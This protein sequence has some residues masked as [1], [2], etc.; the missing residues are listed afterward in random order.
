MGNASPR[1]CGVG[2]HKFVR[3]VGWVRAMRRQ[4]TIQKQAVPDIPRRTKLM[5]PIM[6]YTP[7]TAPLV[8]GL[9]G[10]PKQTEQAGAEFGTASKAHTSNGVNRFFEARTTTGV[11]M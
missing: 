7:A 2:G 5:N 8:I 1:S 4:R 10:S 11:T 6:T 3:L 9:S